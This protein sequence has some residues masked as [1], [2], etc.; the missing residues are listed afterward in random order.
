MGAINTSDYKLNSLDKKE[1]GLNQ[2][3]EGDKVN[4]LLFYNTNCL[5]CTGRAIPFGYELM[6]KNLDQLNLIVV[7]VD[8]A[9]KETS[10]E[11]ILDIFHTKTSPFPI[12]KDQA[13]ALYNALNCEGTPHWIVLSDKGEVLNSIFGSQDN[14][15][16]RLQ[17]ILE[18]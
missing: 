18:E 5:G 11:E 10:S 7:H 14:A 17:Y 16:M 3:L 6:Q 4:I 8:F 15:Q 1:N 9:A 12:Y 2:L 13:A